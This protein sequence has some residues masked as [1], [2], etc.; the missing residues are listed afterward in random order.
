MKKVLF[1]ALFGFVS[2]S[3]GQISNND[4]DKN[5]NV[6]NCLKGDKTE[7]F[8]A[9][10]DELPSIKHCNSGKHCG[11]VAMIYERVSDE[12]MAISYYKKAVRLG[13]YTHYYSLGKIYEKQEDY[14]N[15]KKN[16]EMACDIMDFDKV[17]K[18]TKK[19]ACRALAFIYEKGV[20]GVKQNKTK[21]KR[22]FNKACNLGDNEACD[23]L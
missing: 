4:L 14:K 16:Y 15:A 22:Y 8:V 13:E 10:N 9:I 20:E 7:C 3:F 12:Q 21:A 17:K 23:K 19:A 5:L 18:A 1:A 6:Q 11:V 2:V